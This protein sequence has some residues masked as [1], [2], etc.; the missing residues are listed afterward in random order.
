[1]SV[2]VYRELSVQRFNYAV[3]NIFIQCSTEQ[4]WMDSSSFQLWP[5]PPEGKPPPL[6][7]STFMTSQFVQYASLLMRGELGNIKKAAETKMSPRR[8]AAME[9]L[10]MRRSNLWVWW[11]MQPLSSNHSQCRD[12]R[13]SLFVIFNIFRVRMWP[14]HLVGFCWLFCKINSNDSKT[15][16]CC[17]VCV[18]ALCLHCCFASFRFPS[19]VRGTFIFN[20]TL[21]K[22]GLE[23]QNITT[24]TEQNK[25]LSMF[26]CS[27]NHKN[28]VGQWL[29]DRKW[30]IKQS[31]HQQIDSLST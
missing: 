1:M 19:W 6:E 5:L 31:T 20:F 3:W 14:P 10:S 21:S 12:T 24:Q 4:H 15:T 25:Q 7:K 2:C 13:T 17:V 11:R 9:T 16:D 29:V 27:N 23:S 26:R 30:L 22:G 8:A 28:L 18:P